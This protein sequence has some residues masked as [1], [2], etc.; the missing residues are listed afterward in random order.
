MLLR[1]Y[2]ERAE[3]CVRYLTVSPEVEGVLEMI[4]AARELGITVAI[5]HSGADYE[6]SLIH[7]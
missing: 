3:G 6:L 1:A 5:G 7:I 4:P 2:Q